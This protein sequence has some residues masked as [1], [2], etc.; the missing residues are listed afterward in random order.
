MRSWRESEKERARESIDATVKAEMI[1]QFIDKKL[2][3]NG[4]TLALKLLE[5]LRSRY[6]D[7]KNNQLV[8][9]VKALLLLLRA[10]IM[11]T[12]IELSVNRQL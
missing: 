9:L 11:R 10:V 12:P 8:S 2:E 5:R 7:R 1:I 3:G 6:K 4:S